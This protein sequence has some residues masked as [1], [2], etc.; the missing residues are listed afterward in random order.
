MLVQI[1]SQRVDK[2]SESSVLRAWL[3]VSPW[4]IL[5]APALISPCCLSLYSWEWWAQNESVT[6]QPH[7]GVKTWNMTFPFWDFISSQIILYSA[8]LPLLLCFRT[9]CD[10]YYY[11]SK[12]EQLWLQKKKK[13]MNS[14]QK[15]IQ[16][17]NYTLWQLCLL[18]FAALLINHFTAEF[19]K[20]FLLKV[21]RE[22]DSKS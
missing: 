21:T 9:E 14:R 11:M 22:S 12:A 6:Q 4:G 18:T 2:A 19:P 15:V 7:A 10:N 8:R 3:S 16:K 20:Q 13:N 1:F 17:S 5:A